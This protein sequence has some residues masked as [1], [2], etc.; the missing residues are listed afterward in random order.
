MAER[1]SNGLGILVMMAAMAGFILNDML[2]K[3][4]GES[5]PLSQIVVLRSFFVFVLLSGLI[6]FQSGFSTL[7]PLR[8][9]A[10]TIR[11]LGEIG[12]TVLY[13]SALFRMPLANATAIL[14][15]LPLVVTA[16]SALFLGE[17]VGWRRWTAITIGLMGVLLIVRPG[18]AGF[19]S[20]SLV[21]FSAVFF[22][23]LRD[24]ATRQM[25]PNVST[26]AVAWLTSIAV[27]ILGILLAPFE[28]WQPVSAGSLLFLAGAAG[29]ILLAYVFII[30]AMRTGDIA[31]ISPFRYSIILWAIAIGYLVWDDIPD[32]P[33]Q[34]GIAIL[35]ATGIYTFLR[36]R[37]QSQQ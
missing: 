6:Y 23:A 7:A 34:V 37:G 8:E 19:D 22:M 1:Q 21:A 2:V 12:A 16:G 28:E 29:F 26:F 17:R 32:L 36:E 30:M 35:V 5:L 14:Q 10:V 18:L 9:K 4:A 13:L 27:G 3:L 25:S 11:I 33:T 24:L 31:V 15:V 20:W